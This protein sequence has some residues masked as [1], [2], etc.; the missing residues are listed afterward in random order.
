MSPEEAERKLREKPPD[1]G[2]LSKTSIINSAFTKEL[3]SMTAEGRVLGQTVSA[4]RITALDPKP[5]QRRRWERKMV[6]RE[7]QRRGRLSK[8]QIIKRTERA[9]TTKSPMLKTSMKKLNPLANQIAGKTIE[10]AIVQMRYSVKKSAT[11]VREQLEAARDQA[12]V[13]RGMGLGAIPGADHVTKGLQTM[14]RL[15]D[16]KLHKIKDRT[17][18][19]VDQAWTGKGAYGQDRNPRARGRVD[20]LRLPQTSMIP[21]IHRL[22]NSHG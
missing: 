19:Y 4:T 13:E 16:G 6:I 22:V 12:I 21:P 14:V 18:I 17:G 7:V 5:A 11:V 9:L 8:A 10:D 20:R 2:K 15:K 3:E 1:L